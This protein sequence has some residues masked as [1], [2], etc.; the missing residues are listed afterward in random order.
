MT[1]L[2]EAAI[3]GVLGD[4]LQ[5]VVVEL[6]AHIGEDGP[7][8]EAACKDG[9][10]LIHVM[11]E[12]DPYNAE[13][14]RLLPQSATRDVRLI[15][16]A[17]AD[18]NGLRNFH[19]SY[20]DDGH[21]ASGSLLKPTGHLV[22]FPDIKFGFPISVRCYTLD[23]IFVHQGLTKIDL[24]YVDVQGSERMV[25]AGGQMALRHTRYAFMEAEPR[26]QLYEGEALKAE[27]IELMEG[28]EMVGD[29]DY[30]VLF[31]NTRFE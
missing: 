1:P 22:Y 13:L 9:E 26:V 29:F 24:L 15:E 8:F 3:R 6:G 14:I 19:R 4:I 31:R 20:S 17:C 18:I 23:R 30:N 21:R 16:A 25:I 27:L 11:V 2:E 10:R 7:T 28:W 12:P 5:P